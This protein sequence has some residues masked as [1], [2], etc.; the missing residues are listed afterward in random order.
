M[1]TVRGIGTFG[2]ELK[3]TD[4]NY[5]P[6]SGEPIRLVFGPK[7]SQAPDAGVRVVTTQDGTAQFATQALVDRRWIFVNIGF[8]P[9]GMPLRADHL[10]IAL[11][12]SFVMPQ[13]QGGD[14]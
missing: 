8:T 13:N 9:L 6:L 12:L 14:T 2:V 11:A 7:G 10:A 4:E 3:F 1:R 5:R